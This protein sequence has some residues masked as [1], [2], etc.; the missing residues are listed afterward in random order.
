MASGATESVT[1]HE[2]SVGLT[3]SG[4][5]LDEAEVSVI[6]GMRASVFFKKGEPL[7]PRSRKERSTSTWSYNFDPPVGNPVWPS[8]ED[9]LRHMIERLLPKKDALLELKKRYSIDVTGSALSPCKKQRVYVDRQIILYVE[10][11]NCLG[12]E[13]QRSPKIVD[14]WQQ[15][16]LAETLWS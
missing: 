8:I 3:V 1:V 13:Q 10:P 15:E 11:D 2:Y 16:Q 4:D 6:L 5:D 14:I 9:G 7:S 12:T